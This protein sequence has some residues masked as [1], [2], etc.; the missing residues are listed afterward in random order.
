M[1][2]GYCTLLVV[3]LFVWYLVVKILFSYIT[4]SSVW[5]FF[6]KI[7]S[8]TSKSVCVDVDWSLLSINL[9]YVFTDS[10]HPAHG[11]CKPR[12]AGKSNG[13]TN[14]SWTWCRRWTCC[15]PVA[16]TCSPACLPTT[17]RHCCISGRRRPAQCPQWLT[18][19]GATSTMNSTCWQWECFVG[20]RSRS[21]Q[22]SVSSTVCVALLLW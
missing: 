11:R 8:N 12:C 5:C 22:I 18:A 19:L 13:L 6:G 3:C 4:L 10:W 2:S 20:C 15:P 17:S 14:W 16:A 21:H 9:L 1:F 7:S